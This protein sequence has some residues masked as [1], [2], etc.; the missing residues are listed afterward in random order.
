MGNEKYR[1]PQAFHRRPLD[2]NHGTVRTP[3]AQEIGVEI[4]L[5]PPS[6]TISM[7]CGQC[8]NL[9][10]V[11]KS[12]KVTGLNQRRYAAAGWCG[13]AS[14][15]GARGEMSFSGFKKETKSNLSR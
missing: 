5:L 13:W 3:S 10:S 8:D 6:T 2:R 15:D 11:E 14:I 1:R 7:F 4:P 12:C 9:S